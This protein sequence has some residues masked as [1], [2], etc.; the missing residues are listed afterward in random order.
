M[1]QRLRIGVFDINNGLVMKF[2][3]AFV[4]ALCSIRRGEL[5]SCRVRD[6]I[7]KIIML[8][9]MPNGSVNVA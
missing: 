3:L 9:I 1:L 6:H 4:N 8:Q 2:K 5:N 7:N